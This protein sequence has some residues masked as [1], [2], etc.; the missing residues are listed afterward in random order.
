MKKPLNLS[1]RGS[2][3]TI[4]QQN[5]A[6]KQLVKHIR[7][8]SL[9]DCLNILQILGHTGDRGMSIIGTENRV[10]LKSLVR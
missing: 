2:C 10:K 7:C 8:H 5:L 4:V 9:T 3:E 6:L 1:R